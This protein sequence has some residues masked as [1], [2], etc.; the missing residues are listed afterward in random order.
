M[1][2]NNKFLRWKKSRGENEFE[3]SKKFCKFWDDSIWFLD[4]RKIGKK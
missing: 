3:G 4:E 1:K 2:K